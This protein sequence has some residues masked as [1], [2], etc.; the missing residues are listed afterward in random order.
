MTVQYTPRARRHLDGIAA[1]IETRNAE[2]ARRVGVRIRETIKL[3]GEFPRIAHPGTVP[4]TLEMIV[5]G[6]PFVIVY[7]LDFTSEDVL[8][9]LGV[10]HCAQDR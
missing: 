6:L 1:F 5:P 4:K 7:R 2:A 10:Y 9:I 8:V 3:L